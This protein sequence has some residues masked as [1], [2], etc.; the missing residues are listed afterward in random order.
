MPVPVSAPAKTKKIRVMVVDDSIVARN[1][2]ITGLSAHP[3]I[4]VVG[5]AINA[6][7]AKKELCFLYNK[8]QKPFFGRSF[9]RGFLP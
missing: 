5:Y 9:A 8:K 7:D 4:E 2:L 3:L 6:L 1:L